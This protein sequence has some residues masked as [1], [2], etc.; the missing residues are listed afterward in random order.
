MTDRSTLE[1]FS[2]VPLAF[3]SS[4]DDAYENLTRHLVALKKGIN[5]LR[6]R[7]AKTRSPSVP[8][9]VTRSAASLS[10]SSLQTTDKS[11]AREPIRVFPYPVSFDHKSRFRYI[12]EIAKRKLFFSGKTLVDEKSICIK[13]VRRYGEA[14]HRWLAEDGVAP[15]LI[16]FCKLP[17]GWYMVVME[18]L[19]ESW[20][21]LAL[22]LLDRDR[23]VKGL[24]TKIRAA[25]DNLHRM[26]MV[27][28]D[29]RDANIM[30]REDD[31]KFLFKV[32][33]FDWAGTNGQVTYPKLLN[34]VDVFRPEGVD[35][36]LPIVAQHDQDM[37]DYLLS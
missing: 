21:P 6:E 26:N 17:G 7:Y 3:H 31:G 9:S 35:D 36:G 12:T 27:H 18:H 33:D 5:T 32:V 14:V 13:F 25:I 4:N 28:G 19:D 1:I 24:E 11:P 15:E 23:Y 16:G 22:V 30:V 20:K 34:K 8:R 37:L 2:L 29:L 10:V